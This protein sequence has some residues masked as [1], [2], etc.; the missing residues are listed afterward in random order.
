MSFVPYLHFD[1]DCARAMEFYA[2]VFGAS[3]LEVTRYSEAPDGGP[4]GAIP[5][6]VMHA[7]MTLHEGEALMAS[8]YPAATPHAPAGFSV[9][10][11]VSSV[12]EGSHLAEQLAEGGHVRMAFGPTFFSPGFGMVSDRFGVTWMV[13]VMEHE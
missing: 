5:D 2:K 4:P 12:A 13:G 7:R 1:G 8:D 11:P 9:M 10:R 3:D 6:R